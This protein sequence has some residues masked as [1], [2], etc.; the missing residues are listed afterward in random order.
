MYEG[1]EVLVRTIYPQKN[2]LST[3]SEYGN[4][5]F[6]LQP[7]SI[8]KIPSSTRYLIYN[9]LQLDISLIAKSAAGHPISE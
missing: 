8:R 6:E 9:T 7:L 5:R 2:Y 4:I 3:L 1:G